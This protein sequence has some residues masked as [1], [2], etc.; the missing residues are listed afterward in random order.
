MPHR[1][2]TSSRIIGSDGSLRFATFDERPI[3]LVR[4]GAVERFEVPNPPA[5]QQPLVQAAVDQL[6]GVGQCPSTGE[7]AARTTFVIDEVLRAYRLGESSSQGIT[8]HE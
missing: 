5:I 8:S 6:R 7:S 1:A 4:R 3:E 2:K